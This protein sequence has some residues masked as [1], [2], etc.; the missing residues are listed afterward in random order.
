MF[1]LVNIRLK[2][3]KKINLEKLREG[4]GNK[5]YF[6]LESLLVKFYFLFFFRITLFDFGCGLF[7]VIFGDFIRLVIYYRL[8]VLDFGIIGFFLL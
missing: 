4:R 7:V 1:F 6:C 3:K 5:E 2:E 8:I